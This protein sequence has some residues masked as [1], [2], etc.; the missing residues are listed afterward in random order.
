[1]ESAL[2]FTQL[3]LN[4]HKIQYSVYFER[5]SLFSGLY[6]EVHELTYWSG[7]V[8]GLVSSINYILFIKMS[9]W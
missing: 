4:S 5:Q 3:V 9:E 8:Y 7:N 2:R 1:M 6:P